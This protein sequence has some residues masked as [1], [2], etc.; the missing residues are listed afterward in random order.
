[1]SIK[2]SDKPEA[3]IYDNQDASEHFEP[4]SSTLISKNKTWSCCESESTCFSQDIKVGT[5]M[6]LA[7]SSKASIS[8]PLIIANM[9]AFEAEEVYSSSASPMQIVSKLFYGA[10]EKGVNFVRISCC[11]KKFSTEVHGSKLF[12]YL[13][14]LNACIPNSKRFKFTAQPKTDAEEQVVEYAL[15]GHDS[16]QVK[17]YNEKGDSLSSHSLLREKFHP[18]LVFQVVGSI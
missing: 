3:V 4:S 8:E 5:S 7:G 17:R 6:F 1:M 9:Y 15:G 10:E 13:K 12:G 18:I 14:D 16:T 11:L 2:Q